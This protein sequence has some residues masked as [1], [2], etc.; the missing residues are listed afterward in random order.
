MKY[1]LVYIPCKNRA[2]ALLIGETLVRQKLA[3]CANIPGVMDSIYEWKG[4]LC[5]ERET[6]LIVKTRKSLFKKLETAARKLH[7]YE[8]PCLC[9]FEIT[10]ANQD[11][12][13]WVN[14]QTR[15]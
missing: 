15:T 6:L 3:A 4:K 11:Y 10:S 1:L 7:S 2:Q 9:A 5:R 14:A 8:C 13:A 12:L